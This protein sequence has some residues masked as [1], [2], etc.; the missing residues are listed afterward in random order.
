MLSELRKFGISITASH[1]YLHQLDPDIRHVVPGNAGTLIS[2][3]LG[4]E[5]AGFISRE[6]EPVFDR[7]DLLNLPNYDICLKLM[8]D[9]TPSRPFSATTIQ[10]Q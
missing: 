6:L 9:G 10:F 3:R 5:D 2:F 4:A 8:V 7:I 1:Q